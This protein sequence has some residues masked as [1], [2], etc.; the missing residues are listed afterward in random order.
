MRGETT[1]PASRRLGSSDSRE[2]RRPEQ[3][4]LRNQEE[5]NNKRNSIDVRGGCIG[6]PTWCRRGPRGRKAS[7]TR[8]MDSARLSSVSLIETAFVRETV[9]IEYSVSGPSWPGQLPLKAGGFTKGCMGVPPHAKR[10]ARTTSKN[11]TVTA[12]SH[13][14]FLNQSDPSRKGPWASAQS[15]C[16]QPTR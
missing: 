9:A 11:M 6:P 16:K 12:E 5:K 3:S 2:L 4:S 10:T 7:L 14:R 8:N 13:S 15:V 1:C